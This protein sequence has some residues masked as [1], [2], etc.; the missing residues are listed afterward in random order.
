MRYIIDVSYVEDYKLKIVFDDDTIK[1][2]DL[3]PHLSCEIFEPLNDLEYFKRVKVNP[4][5]ETICWDN[6]ADFAPEFLDE[7]GVPITK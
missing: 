5:I 2:V 3:K 1:L 7:I 6:G 4:D